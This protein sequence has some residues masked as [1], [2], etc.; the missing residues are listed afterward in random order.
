MLFDK[1]IGLIFLVLAISMAILG[2]L[3]KVNDLIV[4]YGNLILAN[5]WFAIRY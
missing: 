2:D 1:F 3:D 4:F 5:I